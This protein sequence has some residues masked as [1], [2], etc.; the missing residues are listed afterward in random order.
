MFNNLIKPSMNVQF[1]IKGLLKNVEPIGITLMHARNAMVHA[2][3]T[4]DINYGH[5]CEVALGMYL[6]IR[7]FPNKNRIV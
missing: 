2:F 7:V 1:L 4:L 5:W 3:L 6:N